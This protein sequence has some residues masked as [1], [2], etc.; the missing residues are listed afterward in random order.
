M[1]ERMRPKN[2]FRESFKNAKKRAYPVIQEFVEKV[3]LKRSFG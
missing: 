1:N 2:L 3:S